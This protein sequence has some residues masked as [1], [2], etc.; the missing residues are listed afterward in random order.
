MARHL[1]TLTV[2]EDNDKPG[3][4]LR[5]SYMW[6]VLDKGEEDYTVNLKLVL[7]KEN[8]DK[9]TATVTSL[10]DYVECNII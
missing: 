4:S 6:E 8:R 3:D 2:W 9:V 10:T 1:I 7:N 5:G